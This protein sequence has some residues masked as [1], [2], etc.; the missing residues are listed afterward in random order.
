MSSI[1]EY[2]TKLRSLKNTQK[3]TRTMKMVAA[4]KL[5]KAQEAQG[6]AKSYAQRITEMTARITA[7][8]HSALHPLLPPI[9]ACAG[10]LIITPTNK[11]SV[12]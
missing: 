10:P 3:I 9:A 7:S 4:S 8:V 12:G 5:R 2:N 11:Y 6:K 1:K